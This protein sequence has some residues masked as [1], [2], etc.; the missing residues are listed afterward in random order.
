M[1]RLRKLSKND[2]DDYFKNLSF[3]VIQTGGNGLAYE[4]QLSKG[5]Y[6]L[7]TDDSG[8]NLPT[9]N[10][11]KTIIGYYD[12]EGEFLG[13]RLYSSLNDLKSDIQSIIN[14]PEILIK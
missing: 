14:N 2:I 3:S 13:D 4:H 1:T 10:D 6:I 11:D 9:S 8:V 5:G 12:D 7:V